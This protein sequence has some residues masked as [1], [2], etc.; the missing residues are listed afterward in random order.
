MSAEKALSSLKGDGKYF[1]TFKTPTATV[2]ETK[3]GWYAGKEIGG[4]DR[5]SPSGRLPGKK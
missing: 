1:G 3:K 2:I 4:A 5:K